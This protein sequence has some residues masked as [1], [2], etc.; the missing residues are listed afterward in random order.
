M[1]DVVF[2]QDADLP[3]IQTRRVAVVG[4]EGLA[5]AHAENL[6]DTGVEVVI[7]SDDNADGSIARAV[8]L[9]FPVKPI[10]ASS[11]WSNVMM[12]LT[13]DAQQQERFETY[14]KPHLVAGN[15]LGFGRADAVRFGR[16]AAPE[17][18]DVFLVEPVASALEVRAEYVAGRGIPHLLAVDTDATA[19]AWG[20]ALSYAKAVG[21]TRVGAYRS[22]FAEA[23]ETKTFLDQIVGADAVPAL[24]RTARD[25]LIESGYRPEVVELLLA[26]QVT[27][28]ATESTV[29]D[30]S[31][32]QRL[33][34]ALAGIRAG[35]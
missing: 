33:R 2:D 29:I 13:E 27:E 9:G 31:A 21:A 16:L 19:T 12:L 35:A 10:A 1:A 32:K 20:L 24:V 6:R 26:G 8:E 30:E 4:F 28:S 17:G 15:A 18:V 14:I 34:D 5:R 23:A 11:A 22:T 25:L 3:I 7:A